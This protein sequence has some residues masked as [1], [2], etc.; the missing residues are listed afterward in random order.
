M[1]PQ[2]RPPGE[3]VAGLLDDARTVV[4]AT[5]TTG[6]AL[7]RLASSLR[8]EGSFRTMTE[9]ICSDATVQE[10]VAEARVILGY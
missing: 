5:L 4:H 6:H 9:V 3:G 7:Q 2:P 10:V 8:L 1:T